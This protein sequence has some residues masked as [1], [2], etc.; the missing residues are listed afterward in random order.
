MAQEQGR[1]RRHGVEYHPTCDISRRTFMVGLLGGLGCAGVASLSG[2]AFPARLGAAL[3]TPAA[4]TIE[5]QLATV[6]DSE[7]VAKRITLM[8]VGDMLIHASVWNTGR[9]PDGSYNYDHFFANLTDEFAK[10]DIAIVNQET[11]LGGTELGIEDFPTF[12]SPQEIGGAEAKAGV[13]V[14][15]SATNHALDQGFDGI[16]IDLAYWREKHPEV[17][18]TG[19]ADS[20]EAADAIL[21]IER[22][23]IKVALLNY[24]QHTNSIPLPDDAPWC[25]KKLHSSDIPGDV[26]RARED[27]ADFVIAFPHWGTEY[28]YA[29]D[30][31]QLKYAQM[32]LDAGVDAIIGTH[33]HV[34]E[35]VEV[36]DGADGKKVPVFWSLGIFVSGMVEI[37]CILGGMAKLTLEKTEDSCKVTDYSLT[38][39]VTHRAPDPSMSVYKLSEYTEELAA[40]NAI[41]NAAGGEDF[42]LQHCY[43]LVGEILGEDFDMDEGLLKGTL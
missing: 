6:Y 9:Q 18:V 39:L 31:D 25:V 36:K 29:P 30:D 28:A 11:I 38:P 12:N 16:K 15:L 8:M 17:V 24:T 13:D 37:P 10:S 1:F 7:R 32:F 14:A 3:D 27:G 42:T 20:Q 35:G 2:C 23:G 43:D 26:K 33:P 21:M 34:L 5:P 41:R 40:Q 4:G 19:L 22:E